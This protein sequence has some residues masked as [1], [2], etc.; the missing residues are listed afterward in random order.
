MQSHFCWR[1]TP[2]VYHLLYKWWCMAWVWIC[3][4]VCVCMCVC[5]HVHMRLCLWISSDD[6]VTWPILKEK[7]P[8]YYDH[9]QNIWSWRCCVSSDMLLLLEMSLGVLPLRTFTVGD[10]SFEQLQ[11]WL[12]C[13]FE[14]DWFGEEQA[15]VGQSHDWCWWEWSVKLIKIK[16]SLSALQGFFWKSFKCF[17]IGSPDFPK[18]A[19]GRL[20]D[21]FS[22]DEEPHVPSALCSSC[23]GQASKRTIV[24]HTLAP[25]PSTYIP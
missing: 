6:K 25:W 1:E 4:C 10:Y 13:S 22:K 23:W 20:G 7:L 21:W 11:R 8:I 14:G 2:T 19:M 17:L 16:S 9:P 5:M 3:V 12:S 15:K 18:R 24:R